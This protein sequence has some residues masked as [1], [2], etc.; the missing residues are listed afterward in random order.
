MGPCT[1]GLNPYGLTRGPTSIRIRRQLWGFKF[2]AKATLFERAKLSDLPLWVHAFAWISFTAVTL[3]FVVLFYAYR[4]VNFWEGWQESRGLRNPSYAE[5]IY[6]D[7]IFRT[8]ANTWSNLAMVFVG[9]YAIALGLHD[10]TRAYD[11]RNGYLVGTPA[12]SI[13]FGIASCYLGFSSGLFHASLTRWGQQLDVAS[14][15][16]PLL[17]LLAIA[18]GKLWSM[19]RPGGWNLWPLLTLAVI[20]ASIYLYVYKWEMSSVRVLS[21]LI[22]ATA[23]LRFPI[24]L[25]NPRYNLS[26]IA[27]SFLALILA[28]FCRQM[29]VAGRFSGPDA[30]LQGHALW[31]LL[32]GTSLACIYIFDRSEYVEPETTQ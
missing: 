10:R 6:M 7:S 25:L 11:I 19:A 18:T 1:N 2:M 28:V 22:L 14:M 32:C 13:L 16:A 20:A 31:H 29:D 4:D 3:A 12:L 5:R 30:W 27:L 26:W 9:L 23:A 24:Y 17:A 15:Y 21:S 8:R